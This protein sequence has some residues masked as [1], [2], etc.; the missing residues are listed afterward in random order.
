MVVIDK[1]GQ[2]IRHRALIAIRQTGS[3][4]HDTTL[5]L[6]DTLNDEHSPV[7]DSSYSGTVYVNE[8]PSRAY[9]ATLLQLRLANVAVEGD[10]FIFRVD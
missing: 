10:V 1:C 6:L 3:H 4:R 5:S 8:V 7:L 9:F 2:R